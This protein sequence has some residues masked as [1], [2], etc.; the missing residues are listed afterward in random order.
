MR[1]WHTILALLCAVGTAWAGPWESLG[2]F[3]GENARLSWRS[4]QGPATRVAADV[5]GQG[6]GLRLMCPM[7][8]ADDRCS[9]DADVALDLSWVTE[10]SLSIRIAKPDAV[11]RCSIYFRSG[12]GWY[13][14]W[15]TPSGDDWQSITL[16][17]EVFGVEGTPAGWG[18]IE[19]IR[20]SLWKGK[21]K[22]TLVDIA[23]LN[24]RCDDIIVIHNSHAKA[25]H[26][27]EMPLI[28]RTSERMVTWLRECGIAAGQLDDDDIANGLPSRCRLALLP[29]NPHPPDSTLAAITEF[30]AGGG[31][32]ITAYNLPPTL[33]PVLGLVGKEWAPTGPTAQFSTMRFTGD[34]DCGIPESLRQD[35]WNASVPKLTNATAMAHWENAAGILSDI[36]AVTINTN[37][38]FIGHILTN[39]DRGR[40]K[41]FLLALTA[42]LLPDM[43]QE[44]AQDFIEQSVGLLSFPTWEEARA[45]IMETAE[46][47]DR[48]LSGM[49]R[50]DAVDRYLE[51]TMEQ[52]DEIPFGELLLRAD[53]TRTLIQET[54]FNVVANRGVGDEFRG[55]WC[56]SARGVPGLPWTETV[57]AIEEAGFNAL[58]ANMLW[59]GVAYYPSDVVPTSPE[60]QTRGDLLAECLDACCQHGIELHLW[61]V[62]WNLLHASPGFVAQLR[63]ERRLQQ[64]VDG[65]EMAWL[66]PS[67]PRNRDY[68]LS[69]A[70]EA[71][72]TYAVHG[73][74][75]DYIRYPGSQSCFCP[76]CRERFEAAT[77]ISV[78]N[79]PGDVVDGP[80]R[81]AFNTW[82]CE[83]ITTFV[84]QSSKALRAARDG[85]KISAAVFPSW[86]S[87]CDSIAQ[88]WVTWAREGY[89]DFL[90]P[91]N[92]VTDDA[93]A[94]ELITTQLAAVD[95]VVPI[96]PGLGPSAKSLAPEQ[97]V[98]Q[99]DLVR[100]AGAKGV[101]LF[102]LDRDLLELHLPALSVGAMRP[103]P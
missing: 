33:A 82:R 29:Y 66:C 22:N 86:P 42:T 78:T 91:M 58:F 1:K 103:R 57:D 72:R 56:H 3:E 30:V 94:T 63:A 8:T 16:S 102:E 79:W 47:H 67:D 39:I 28:R 69:A 65:K 4:E 55:L 6:P 7:E 84:A 88:D 23:G 18:A 44:L 74:H 52:M 68:E 10:I 62:C 12:E 60:V 53:V 100:E 99:L 14:G 89:V 48:I 37:G 92:Y 59:A 75:F 49:V 50:L 43:K 83:Q 61:K 71:V 76:G 41:Q 25:A 9:W 96:Y 24:A 87:T 97:V 101:V 2:G 40:K 11:K 36:P 73:I 98:H 15:F 35:S 95:G 21:A 77:C 5:A 27:G 81:E 13:A 51:G 64:T 54:Y 20:I 93:E 38:A 46:T 32:I 80:H 26:P 19:G 85:I 31:K 90:C 34:S 17:R 45:F 70:V